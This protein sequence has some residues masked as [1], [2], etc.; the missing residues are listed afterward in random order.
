VISCTQCCRSS[1]DVLLLFVTN[2]VALKISKYY[3]MFSTQAM[4]TKAVTIPDNNTLS[5]CT[6]SL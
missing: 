4:H 6:A 2:Y 5:A 3:K 1:V